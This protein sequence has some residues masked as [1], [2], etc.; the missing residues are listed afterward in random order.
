MSVDATSA[1]F[2][3]KYIYSESVLNSPYVYHKIKTN[4]EILAG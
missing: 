1:I 3:L 4:K 2:H